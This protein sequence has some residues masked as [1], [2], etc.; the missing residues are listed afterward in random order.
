M[1]TRAKFPARGYEVD[2]AF[3]ASETE[4]MLRVAIAEWLDLMLKMKQGLREK[5]V[6]DRSFLQKLSRVRSGG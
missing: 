2:F 1:P 6:T 4:N 3:C 5:D